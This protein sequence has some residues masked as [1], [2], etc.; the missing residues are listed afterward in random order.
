MGYS[1]HSIHGGV[2]KELSHL[3][4]AAQGP[5]TEF[6]SPSRHIF[7]CQWSDRCRSFSPGCL[8]VLDTSNTVISEISGGR[9]VSGNAVTPLSPTG[10][11]SAFADSV[12]LKAHSIPER[13]HAERLHAAADAV[14]RPTA[15]C[16]ASC[17]TCVDEHDMRGEAAESRC[18]GSSQQSLS[19]VAGRNHGDSRIPSKC[20]EV[21]Y[22]RRRVCQ[23]H[24]QNAETPLGG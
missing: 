20:G 16:R 1:L 12:R 18:T 22:L 6:P 3:H 23:S 17:T 10:D 7:F 13:R 21:L 9:H 19:A 4:Q 5:R 2:G 24:Q 11:T 15:A 14:A 8:P